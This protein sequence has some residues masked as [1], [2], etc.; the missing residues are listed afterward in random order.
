MEALEQN[1]HSEDVG[2]AD[3]EVRGR[4]RKVVRAATNGSRVEIEEAYRAYAVK[5]KELGNRA[6]TPEVFI[7]V[8]AEFCRECE[9]EIA[10]RGRKV[11]LLNMRLASQVR[12]LTA[13]TAT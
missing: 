2:S 8:M 12:S 3:K 9:I 10:T 6:E 13:T 5:C 7:D 4:F 1:L 11:Y